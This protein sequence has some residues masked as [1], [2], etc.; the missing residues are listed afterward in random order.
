VGDGSPVVVSRCPSG[1]SIE[2]RDPC[3]GDVLASDPR[4]HRARREH[5]GGWD[6]Q[7]AR[8]LADPAEHRRRTSRRDDV[9]RLAQPVRRE[10]RLEARHRLRLRGHDHTAGPRSIKAANGAPGPA[11]APSA[12]A[13]R[14][15][16]E[17]ADAGAEQPASGDDDNDRFGAFHDVDIGALIDHDND[18]D[19]NN[20]A[21]DADPAADVADDN[22]DDPWRHDYDRASDDDDSCADHHDEQ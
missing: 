16:A 1:C 12:R 15:G 6:R 22:L 8:A 9:V 2:Q 18:N 4:R 7:L 19:N 10:R 21:P 5:G 14:H 3:T 17:P 13:S 11:G 20:G